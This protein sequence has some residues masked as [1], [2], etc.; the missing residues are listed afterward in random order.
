MVFSSVH[1]VHILSASPLGLGD[2]GYQCLVLC[3]AVSELYLGIAASDG[4][5]V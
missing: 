4:H 5:L 3:E 1:P 2:V